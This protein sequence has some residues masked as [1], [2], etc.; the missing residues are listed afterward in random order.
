MKVLK[1]RTRIL[2]NWCIHIIFIVVTKYAA[3]VVVLERVVIVQQLMKTVNRRCKKYYF[4]VIYI[5]P[6]PTGV[7]LIDLNRRIFL[8]TM[9]GKFYIINLRHSVQRDIGN[10][11]RGNYFYTQPSSAN[12]H[13]HHACNNKME[14]SV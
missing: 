12:T 13:T 5:R 6:V 9:T 4:T 2:N 8:G 10:N 11:A 7:W 14:V 3:G 1:F